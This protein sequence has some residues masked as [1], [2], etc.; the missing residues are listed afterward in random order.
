MKPILIIKNVTA[1]GAGM[2][3]D[4]LKVRQIAYEIID[5]EKAQ[6]IPA[7]QN[8]QAVIVCGGPDSAND[9]T[10]KIKEELASIK[11]ILDL[12]IPYLGICLGLQTLVKAA[13]G[14][15]M[16]SPIKEIG[17]RDPEDKSF[18]IELTPEGQADPLFKG[19]SNVFKVFQLHGETV[20]L[21]PAMTLLGVGKF[22]PNQ[23]VRVAPAQYGLQCHFE[24]TR[25]MFELWLNEDPDLKALD[26]EKVRA[27]YEE[28]KGEYEKVGKK[29]FENWLGMVG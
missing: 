10:P 3:E 11:Q 23:I 8:Y 15:V 21:T 2:L 27:D 18:T 9:E 6:P 22:C 29:L 19:L 7:P 17:F 13:G 14:K 25:E 28:I 4:I 24:L 5:L 1:E 12:G 26:T 20:E 16:E